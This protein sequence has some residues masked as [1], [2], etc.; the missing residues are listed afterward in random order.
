MKTLIVYVSPGYGNTEKVAKAIG[1]SL[2]AVLRFPDDVDKDLS[3]YDL[4]GF[5]SGIYYG[6]HDESLLDFVNGSLPMNTK[7]FI[8]STR[9]MG[10]PWLYHWFLRKA[11]LDK[12]C[13]LVGEFS[14]KGFDDAGFLKLFGGVNKGRPNA[15]DL[16]KAVR[17]AESLKENLRVG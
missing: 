7:A 3:M 15:E 17:F 10:P 14:C 16:E 1:K 8:F 11:L 2:D 5:G 6:K 13:T 4:L 9:G 12:G